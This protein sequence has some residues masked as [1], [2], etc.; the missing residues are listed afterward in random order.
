MV[1]LVTFP[2]CNCKVLVYCFEN[3]KNVTTG[4]IVNG[5]QIVLP[6]DVWDAEKELY[7]S[8]IVNDNEII[9][10]IPSLPF[11]ML[12][13]S[14]RRHDQLIQMGINC[15]RCQE[16]HDITMNDVFSNPSRCQKKLRLLFP[17]D[18]LSLT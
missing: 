12:H 15:E 13:D 5:F 1:N 11:I 3:L 2:E 14:S 16:A 9:L 7:K 10:T 6:V 8:E 17:G 4:D 18:I